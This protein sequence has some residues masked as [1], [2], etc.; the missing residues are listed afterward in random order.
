MARVSRAGRHSTP[1]RVRL[2]LQPRTR[3]PKR[4]KD[5]KFD[6]SHKEPE[7]AANESKAAGE[8]EGAGSGGDGGELLL[9]LPFEMFAEASTTTCHLPR[10][11]PVLTYIILDR[12]VPTWSCATSYTSPS[13]QRSCTRSCLLAMRARSGLAAA[14]AWATACRKTGPRFNSHS[15]L[16][17]KVVRYNEYD[18]C[19]T[20][21]R[22]LRL[23]SRSIAGR[24]AITTN[25][26]SRG[27]F[28]FATTALALASTLLRLP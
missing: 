26:N 7:A 13:R 18:H 2:I 8:L 14:S 10:S 27:W 20:S 19:P 9:R 1:L 16:L 3:R 28:G 21:D 6:A 15:S 22:S 23:Q 11:P 5:S 25:S 24:Q 17:V 4:D 12:S